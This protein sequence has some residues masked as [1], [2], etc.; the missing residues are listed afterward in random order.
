MFELLIVVALVAAA[1]P[2]LSRRRYPGIIVAVAITAP[3]FLV[4]SNVTT[5]LIS[6]PAPHLG[7]RD[8]V[9]AAVANAIVAAVLSPLVIA[10]RR[11]SEKRERLIWWR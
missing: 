6:P 10:V 5:G 4:I 2:L 8:L 1:E 11:R 3:F 9:L 7:L